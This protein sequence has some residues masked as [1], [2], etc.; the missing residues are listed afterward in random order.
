MK[1]HDRA[2][3]GEISGQ[4]IVISGLNDLARPQVQ[5]RL[6]GRVGRVKARFLQLFKKLEQVPADSL[7]IQQIRRSLLSEG[8]DVIS[9]TCLN[10]MCLV[11]VLDHGS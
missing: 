2:Y 11:T 6:I 9:D 7:R 1:G 8:G 3:R 5:N 4:Q 10:L